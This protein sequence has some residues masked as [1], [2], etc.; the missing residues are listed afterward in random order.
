MATGRRQ[1]SGGSTGTT[2]V[3]RSLAPKAW[4]AWASQARSNAGASQPIWIDA[5]HACTGSSTCSERPTPRA[6][7]FVARVRNQTRAEMSGQVGPE[8]NGEDGRAALVL[9]LAAIRSVETGQPVRIAE[10]THRAL[11]PGDVQRAHRH[12]TRA[13]AISGPRPRVENRARCPATPADG[14]VT[15]E[16]HTEAFTRRRTRGVTRRRHRRR[17]TE[18]SQTERR[19]T[20]ASHGGRHT[21]ASHGGVTRRRHTEASHAGAHAGVTRRASHGPLLSPASVRVT[22]GVMQSVT[23][24]SQTRHRPPHSTPTCPAGGRAPREHL[25]SAGLR[26]TQRLIRRSNLLSEVY[27]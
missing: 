16:R 5:P 12:A 1:L 27:S 7:A 24:A 11:S 14:H 9:A 20:E 25:A 17:H 4:P 22:E 2:S 19:H 6:C 26:T 21:E 23:R 15:F 3:R 18:A 8:A 13:A 10:I